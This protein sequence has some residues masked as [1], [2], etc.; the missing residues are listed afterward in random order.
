MSEIKINA[1]L[2][3][4]YL[5][6]GVMPRERTAFEGVTFDP[7]TGQSWARVTN[8]PARRDKP[9]LAVTDSKEY[10]GIY[11]ID[12]FWPKGTGTGPILMAADQVM[13]HFEPHTS[14]EYQG[15]RVKL[16]RVERSQ[17]RTEDLWQSI[18]I[19]I[20]YWACLA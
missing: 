7:V 16:R 6:C 8:M 4:A 5:A 20:Y 9:G 12:L 17:L 13:N 11:Q 18:S 14:I 19:D 15:Q 1:A 10:A 3:S 2:V